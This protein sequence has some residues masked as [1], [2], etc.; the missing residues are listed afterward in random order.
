MTYPRSHLVDPVGGTYHVCSRCVRR[1]FLCGVDENSGRD[2]SH[3]R[4]WIERRI[5]EL[6]E[7]FSVSIYAYAVM[8]NHYH[9]VLSVE[10]ETLTDVEVADKWLLLCPVKAKNTS[11]K[12]CH[13]ASKL[14]ILGDSDRLA[15]LR[16]RLRSLSWFM[17]FIN[18]PL[19]RMANQEDRCK[20]RFWE[21]RF[22][23]QI[24]L[25]EA[26][27]LACMVYVDLNPVRACISSGPATSDFTSI[28]HRIRHCTVMHSL[29]QV[30]A[31]TVS[32]KQVPFAPISLSGYLKLLHWT[33]MSQSIRS[34]PLPIEVRHNLLTN[35]TSTDEW[36][37]DHMP[38]PDYWPRALGSIDTLRE[39]ARLIGQCWIKRRR[40][41]VDH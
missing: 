31:I 32:K 22:K 36:F 28:Q 38:E 2:F 19:A 10:S 37:R 39:Y 13:E 4:E 17:R 40:R 18:E 8:S 26:S 33:K 11:Q 9:I 29:Q 14:A 27:V 12:Y 35:H 5:L 7:I 30:K 6:S 16:K 20:G 3:R 1:S 15:E 25:D 34:H 23:S 24:L 41:T 21:G